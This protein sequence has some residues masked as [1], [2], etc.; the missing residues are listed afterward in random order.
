MMMKKCF[1]AAMVVGMSVAAM[2]A[3]ACTN[4]L[5]GKKASADGSAMITY[6][7]DSHCPL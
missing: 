5:V 3:D 7:A 4:L 1:F 2:P 6:A